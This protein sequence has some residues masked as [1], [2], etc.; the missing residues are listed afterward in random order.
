MIKKL[1]VLAQD[2]GTYNTIVLEDSIGMLYMATVLPN[3]DI[4]LE[5]GKEY[6]LQLTETRAGETSYLDE[7]G[8][9]VY[10]KYTNTY[11]TKSVPKNYTAEDMTTIKLTQELC[12]G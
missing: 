6:Y 7:E 11:I 9:R 1:R 12:I 8:N 3:W 10:H 5:D 4:R 2:R